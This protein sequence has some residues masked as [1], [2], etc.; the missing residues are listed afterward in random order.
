[1]RDRLLINISKH[2]FLTS[3]ASRIDKEPGSNRRKN[4]MDGTPK[5]KERKRRL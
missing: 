2:I 3:H 5:A 4:A 1:M